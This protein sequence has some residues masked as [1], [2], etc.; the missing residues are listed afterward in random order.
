MTFPRWLEVTNSLSLRVD[1]ELTKSQKG[2]KLTEL[3]YS[4]G[5]VRTN[6]LS[7]PNFTAKTSREFDFFVDIPARWALDHMGPPVNSRKQ[8]VK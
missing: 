7:D 5:V 2:H 6:Q 4:L 1:G 3:P 8:M